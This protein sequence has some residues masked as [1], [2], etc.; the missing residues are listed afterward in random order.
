MTLC[1]YRLK[2]LQTLTGEFPYQTPAG[3]FQNKLFLQYLVVFV[4]VR[5]RNEVK[6]TDN[7]RFRIIRFTAAGGDLCL[8]GTILVR[9]LRL[10]IQLRAELGPGDV[11]VI[12]VEAL[13]HPL[14][15]DV[16]Q[17]LKRL[18]DVYVVFSTRLEEL[19]TWRGG[20]D[21]GWG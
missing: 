15:D 19:K 20:G 11:G 4:W 21:G 1:V 2:L 10:L 9:S 6:P 14:T 16:H 17:P 18:L 5:I 13:C 3:L 8:A 7:K 12:V